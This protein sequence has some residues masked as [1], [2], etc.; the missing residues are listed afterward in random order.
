MQ[1]ESLSGHVPAFQQSEA[2]RLSAFS[3]RVG[4]GLENMW[5][6]QCVNKLPRGTK[7]RRAA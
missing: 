2:F 7:V 5:I 1:D 4:E 6:A 3:D